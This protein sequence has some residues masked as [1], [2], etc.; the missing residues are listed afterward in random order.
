MPKWVLEEEQLASKSK[1]F[2]SAIEV[3]KQEVL[4]KEQA[5]SLVPVV[6]K[7]KIIDD[8]IA[9]THR[10]EVSN[11]FRTGTTNNVLGLAESDEIIIKLEGSRETEVIIERLQ[12]TDKY[13][14]ALSCIDSIEGFRPAIV[15]SD[16]KGKVD[17]KLKLIDYQ[18][19]EQNNSIRR[20][21]E[22]SMLKLG[23]QVNKTNY[24]T[25]HIVYN[26]KSV[27]LDTFEKIKNEEAF[28]AVFSIEPMPIYKVVLDMLPNDDVIDISVP[29]E[30]KEYVTVGILDSGI[31]DIPHLKPWLIKERWT[32][33]H[34]EYINKS[35]GTF[36]SGV[37]LYGD[38]LEGQ[39]WV[40]SV[41]VKILDACVFPDTNKE[42]ISEDELIRNIQEAVKMYHKSVKIW[43]LS[44]SIARPVDEFSFSDFAIALDALQD[45]YNVLICKSAG[46]CTNFL[47]GHP[48]GKIHEGADSVRSI[49]V[50]SIAHK[51]SK[52]DFSEI[53][54]PSPFTRIGRGPS[55]IIKPEI[56]HY[57]GNAGV[58]NQGK[59]VTTGVKSFGLNGSI[60]QSI[61][62]SFSTPRIT[63]LAAALYQEMAEDFDPLLL[64]GLIMH[65][66]SYSE[67]LKIPIA[68]RVNQV[69]FG[70]PQSVKDIL[71]NDPNEVTLILRDEISKG[72]YIDIMD[73]PMPECL[74]DGDFYNGQIILTLVYNPILEPSQRA[75]YCQSNID[76]KMGTFD[77][78]K[79][80]DT[81]RK[82][83]LNPVGRDGSKNLLLEGCYSK[84]KMKNKADDFALK[85]RL[86]IQYGD[87]YYPVKKFAVDLSEMTESNQVKYLTK[88]KKWFLSLRG[89]FREYIETKAQIESSNLSQEFCLLVTI[90]DPTGTKPVYDQVT[91]KLDEYNFWHN[92]IKLQNDI[93]LHI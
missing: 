86:L 71:Y 4:K 73:F 89:L 12:N 61:G 78:K 60:C 57:G 35:H 16:K 55:F 26:V 72:E 58:D 18:N 27:D 14:Y 82:N 67:N 1:A 81:T 62:T 3:F 59:I 38:K 42:G 24:T 79:D 90:K 11:L 80:R 28:G 33:Y 69:G 87:K 45:E 84:R 15:K 23:L 46:N 54:N 64:K 7:A 22:N 41:G 76:I 44:I 68:E 30:G 43:N 85:E 56:V 13:A 34:E 50:G 32:A 63:A 6:I 36:V 70:K 48:K 88:D 47:T 20:Y 10:R 93:K 25:D 19:Y 37:V 65:S 66:A 29:E 83:I 74:I 75:E 5:N 49:V 53:D 17:Y 52:N 91:Q 31:A 39:E 40:G 51:Q 9:K 8:A 21:F 2:I 77:T 92:N